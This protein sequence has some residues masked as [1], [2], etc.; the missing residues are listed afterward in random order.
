MTQKQGVAHF[1]SNMVSNQT[2]PGLCPNSFPYEGEISGW[3]FDLS[4]PKVLFKTEETTSSTSLD[5]VGAKLYNPQNV[6]D[7][8]IFQTSVEHET[9]D[10]LTHK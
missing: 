8:I 3:L 4:N 7:M 2:A 9:E 6:K 5:F 10:C 1:D